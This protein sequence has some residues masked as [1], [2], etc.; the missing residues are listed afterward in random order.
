[1]S[2]T[3]EKATKRQLKLRLAIDGPS[4]SGKTYTA[5]VAATAMLAEVQPDRQPGS[6]RIAVIDTERGSA[7]LYSD[8]FDFDVLELDYFSPEIYIDSIHAAEEQGYSVIVI[9]SL[10]HAWEGEG[11]A[12]DLVD[13]ATARKG[14]NAFAAWKEVT[15]LQR[16]LVETILRSPAHIVATMRSKMDYVMEKDDKGKTVI[17]KVGMAPIQ[18][19]GM[20]YEFTIVGDMDLDHNF[21]VTKSRCDLVA[22]KV[23]RKPDA[24]FFKKI[25]DWLNSGEP[26]LPKVEITSARAGDDRPG[27]NAWNAWFTLAD[28]AAGLG[29]EVPDTDPDITV[30]ALRQLYAE[31]KTQVRLAEV[32]QE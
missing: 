31:L 4:G 19:Q 30:G 22:D 18:R 20:E 6:G 17:R 13:Q 8:Q 26:A 16:K 25:L 2:F 28:Q 21:N 10:S 29:I 5:L 7:C 11:G 24:K 15:P 3:F 12:L 1:M 27:E 23:V 32:S 14:G 9:D